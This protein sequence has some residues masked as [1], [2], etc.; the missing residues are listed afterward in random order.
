MRKRRES[1]ITH[2]TDWD[3]YGKPITLS[4]NGEEEFKTG[5][6]G[7]LSLLLTCSSEFTSWLASSK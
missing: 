6:G 2:F 4:I 1:F 5:I 7:L 3:M